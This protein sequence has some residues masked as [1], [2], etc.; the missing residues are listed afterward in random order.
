[1]AT[2]VA[3]IILVNGVQY[4]YNIISVL[5][6]LIFYYEVLNKL[7]YVTKGNKPSKKEL[8]NTA[9][10]A[11]N[12]LFFGAKITTTKNEINEKKH[13]KKIKSSNMYIMPFYQRVCDL[14]EYISVQRET[15]KQR[16]REKIQRRVSEYKMKIDT[17]AD[18]KEEVKMHDIGYTR[19]GV[20]SFYTDPSKLLEHVCESALKFATASGKYTSDDLVQLQML[21][22]N[23][24]RKEPRS[25]DEFYKFREVFLYLDVKCKHCNHSHASEGVHKAVYSPEYICHLQDKK[26]KMIYQNVAVIEWEHDVC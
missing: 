8:M 6:T 19:C 17:E 15:K 18:L 4:S 21:I 20:C 1:M 24:G 7:D 5:N 2:V 10:I 12:I 3:S 26:N 14:L 16:R 9:E 11:G 22:M 25:P 13:P 23:A